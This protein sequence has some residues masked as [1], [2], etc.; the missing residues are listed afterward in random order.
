[1]LRRA[2]SAYASL[3]RGDNEIGCR[4]C[5]L[6]GED[7]HQHL[8]ARAIAIGIEIELAALPVV[9]EAVVGILCF[10]AEREGIGPA[11]V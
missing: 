7:C 10:G 1:M 2:K 3:G 8:L 11:D 5:V 9:D 4:D 6:V